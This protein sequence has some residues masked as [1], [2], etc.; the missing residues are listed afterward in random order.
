M[1]SPA[2]FQET[3]E[4]STLRIE[5][6]NRQVPKDRF[7]GWFLVV[8]WLVWAPITL[9]ATGTLLFGGPELSLAIFLAVWLVFGWLAPNG[10]LGC[11]CNFP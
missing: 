5:W 1:E 7:A 9:I 8:F 11:Q 4:G 6:D 2:P 3:Q 10:F